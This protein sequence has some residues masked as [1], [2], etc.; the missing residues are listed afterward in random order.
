MCVLAPKGNNKQQGFGIMLTTGQCVQISE[1]EAGI[2]IEAGSLVGGA[3]VYKVVRAF[4]DESETIFVTDPIAITP[5]C[6]LCQE[7]PLWYEGRCGLH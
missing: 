7:C 6:P 3:D 2:V 4:D 5:G 1:D